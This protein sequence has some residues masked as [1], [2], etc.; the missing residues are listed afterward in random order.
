[1]HATTTSE[2]IKTAGICHVAID[3]SDLERSLQF[4]TAMFDMEILSRSDRIVHLKSAGADDSFF[5]FLADGPVN[6]RECGLTHFHFGFKIDDR[7]FDR[8]LDYIKRNNIPVHQNPH[9]EPGR[10]V[11]ILDPDG[12]VIQLEPGDCGG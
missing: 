7:N 6:P 8:A 2:R 3:V 12:Y 5:L 9:R 4:Y 11:Y 1:M 10:F